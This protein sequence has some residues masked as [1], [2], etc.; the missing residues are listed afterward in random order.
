MAE[1]QTIQ[2]HDKFQKLIEQYTKDKKRLAELEAAL[3]DRDKDNSGFIAQINKLQSDLQ[4]LRDTNSSLQQEI[5]RMKQQNQEL[6]ST[7][8]GFEDFA[9]DLNGRIDQLLPQIEKL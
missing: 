2:L 5:A 7:L 6:Q 3:Q 4:Q 9:S 8:A 1:N